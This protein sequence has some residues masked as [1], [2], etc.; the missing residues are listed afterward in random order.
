M[1]D[2]W[3]S[4]LLDGVMPSTL[5]YDEFVSSLVTRADGTVVFQDL[6]VLV[7]FVGGLLLSDC[8]LDVISTMHPE[9]TPSQIIYAAVWENSRRSKLQ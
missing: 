1:S 3:Q 7:S 9:L 5:T 6:N 4:N 2:T 8:P